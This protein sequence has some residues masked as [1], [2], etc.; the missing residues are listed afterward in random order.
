MAHG[1]D[2]GPTE[3]TAEELARASHADLEYLV[4]P[5]GTEYEHTDASVWTIV[6]FGLWLAVSAVIIHFG[7][8][9]MYMMLQNQASVQQQEAGQRY[10]LAAST[11]PRLP[12]APRLQQ[13][14]RNEMYQLRLDQEQKLDTYGWVNKDAGTVH[15]PIDEAMK[16]VIQRGIVQSRPEDP[17]NPMPTPGLMPSDASSGRVMERRRQ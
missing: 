2:S 1:H 12:P 11:E 5:P 14:P 15:I 3:A 7:L 16:L 10:P 8:G 13:F 6:K 9:L 17:A 4:N